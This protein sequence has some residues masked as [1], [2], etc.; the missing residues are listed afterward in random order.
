LRQQ[1]LKEVVLL[2]EEQLEVEPEVLEVEQLFLMEVH[3]VVTLIQ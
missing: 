2:E 1:Y 3:L